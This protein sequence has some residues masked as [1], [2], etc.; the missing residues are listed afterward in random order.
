MAWLRSWPDPRSLKFV[1]DYKKAYGD[2]PN[3]HAYTHWESVHLLADAI[4]AAG[5]VKTADVRAALAKIH[6]ESVMGPVTFDD[7]QQAVV[8]IVLLE[9]VNGHAVNKGVL[10]SRVDYSAH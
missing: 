8:P 6:Y 5:S 9:V 3:V 1:D 4:K 7:H 2:V 10:S